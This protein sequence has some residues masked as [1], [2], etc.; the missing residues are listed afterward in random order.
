MSALSFEYISKY[1]KKTNKSL[2][3]GR[4]IKITSNNKIMDGET[5]LRSN[6][7]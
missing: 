2:V 7:Q 5:K 6:Y 3:C 4:K 1:L